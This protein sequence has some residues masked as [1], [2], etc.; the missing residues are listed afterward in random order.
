VAQEWTVTAIPNTSRYLG[1][2]GKTSREL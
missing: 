1:W 2:K